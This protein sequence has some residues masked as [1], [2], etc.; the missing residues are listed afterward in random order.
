MGSP[1]SIGA[2][3]AVTENFHSQM[4]P[5]GS[6]NNHAEF[7]FASSISNSAARHYTMRAY[8]RQQRRSEGFQRSFV[9][10]KLYPE[11]SYPKRHRHRIRKLL[12]NLDLDNWIEAARILVP[13]WDIYMKFFLCSR[14]EVQRTYY[15]NESPALRTTTTV[16]KLQ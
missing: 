11:I 6:H 16:S 2:G 12:R 1:K 13:W 8:W 4:Y 9:A 10:K 5:L 15:P 14:K 7:Q 3:D